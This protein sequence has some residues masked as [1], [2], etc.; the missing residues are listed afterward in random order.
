MILQETLEDGTHVGCGAQRNAVHEICLGQARP[1]AKDLVAIDGSAKQERDRGNTVVGARGAVDIGPSTHFGDAD[2]RGRLPGRFTHL[3]P[4][5]IEAG[6]K[7]RQFRCEDRGLGCMR[8]PAA[9]TQHGD[10]GPGGILQ[11]SGGADER[12][13]QPARSRGNRRA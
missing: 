11:Q 13:H 3:D 8:V 4:E 10:A 7:F 12:P 9:S 1:A 5:G 2:D 6:I